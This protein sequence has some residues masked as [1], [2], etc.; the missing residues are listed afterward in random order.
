MHNTPSALPFIDRP[1]P[2]T[3]SA[4]EFTAA[5]RLHPG[6]VALISADA[7]GGPVAM[8]ATSVASVCAD[9]PLLMFS[10]SARTSAAA[11]VRTAETVVVHL[12]DARSHDLALLGAARGA[13]RFADASRWT[14]LLTGE[15]IFPDAAAW[16]RVKPL[17]R[18]DAGG[19]TVVVAQALQLGART[20]DREAPADQDGLVYVNRTWHRIGSHSAIR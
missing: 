19:S 2:R 7:G 1:L 11:T 9:P 16:I 5:F 15:P 6:G 3:C 18:I 13:D 8:T 10:L 12:L 20:D 4:E 17:H 14:R